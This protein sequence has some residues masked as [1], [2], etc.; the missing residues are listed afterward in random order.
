MSRLDEAV[1]P[2]LHL[3]VED[4]QSAILVREIIASAPEGHE[5]LVRLDIAAVGPANV[6][7]MMGQ[8]SATGRLPYPALAVI[9]A[10]E[11]VTNGCL[12]LPGTL[13][14]E[15]VIFYRLKRKGVA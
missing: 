7:Q 10:D 13:A 1:H 5:I 14:P 4:R 15:R 11:D 8:L 3:F 2:E 6:V 12:K 9:D